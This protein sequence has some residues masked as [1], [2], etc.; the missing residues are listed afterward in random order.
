MPCDRSENR[1]RLYLFHT[2]AGLLLNR[3]DTRRR[4]KAT[5]HVAKP[6]LDTRMRAI[7]LVLQEPLTDILMTLGISSM[8]DVTDD[9]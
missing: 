3:R 9:L 8:P 6:G 4:T 7:M 2:T 5:T 1:T